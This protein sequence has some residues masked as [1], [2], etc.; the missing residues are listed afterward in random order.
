MWAASV[1]LFAAVVYAAAAAAVVY[2]WRRSIPAVR[3]DPI[4]LGSSPLPQSQK[5]K[6]SASFGLPPLWAL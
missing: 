3:L 6:M 2:A 4:D 1:T 5:R